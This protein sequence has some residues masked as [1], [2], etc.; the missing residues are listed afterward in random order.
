MRQQ[1]IQVS[2]YGLGY[3]GIP[4]LA[5]L[6]ESGLSVCG[7]DIIEDKVQQLNEGQLFYPEEKI[8]QLIDSARTKGLLSANTVPQP[9]DVHIIVVP[10]PL[11]FNSKYKPQPD[12]SAVINAA[13]TIS[14]VLRKGDLIIIESTCPVGTTQYIKSLISDLTGFG[15]LD[16]DV[17]YCPERVLP[18]NIYFEL[19]N[20]NRI[21][22]GEIKQYLDIAFKL[23]ERFCVGEIHLTTAKTA[24]MVKLVENS[25]RDVNIA[26]ANEIS[27]LADSFECDHKLVIQLSNMHPRV[28]ILQPGCGVGGHC[29][30][31]DPYFLV[32]ADSDNTHLIKAARSVNSKKPE[33]VA[34]KI[35]SFIQ[36]HESSLTNISIC[37][38]GLAYKP[39]VDDYRESPSIEILKILSNSPLDVYAHD[40]FCKPTI[41]GCHLLDKDFDFESFKYKFILVGHDMYFS[42]SILMSSISANFAD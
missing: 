1:S 4:T 36:R 29:I 26:F 32:S 7:I 22:G 37:C 17:V 38:L 21:I 10:T 13:K 2:V 34:N 19:R 11:E 41:P 8:Q 42:D 31:V 5:V 20:N 6:A 16:F 15:S 40:P 23:Y 35:L 12:L 39:N 33:W 28:N 9:S 3:I 27:M 30:A 14:T 18:G 24:E 25:Y